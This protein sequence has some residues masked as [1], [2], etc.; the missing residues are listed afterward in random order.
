MSHNISERGELLLD[1]KF[2]VL[3]HG[4]VR[5]VDYMGTDE[6]IVQSA[7]VSYGE[8]TK[9]SREDKELI[10]YLLRNAHF[11]PFEQVVFT[12]HCKMPIFVA[13]QWIRHR[14]A[15]INEISGRYSEL[16]SEAYLPDLERIQPQSTTNKQ[17]SD[18]SG[19][20]LETQ[21]LIRSSMEEEQDYAFQYYRECLDNHNVS[22]EI[23][24]INLPLSTYTEWYWQIDLRNLFNFLK[25]R[26]DSHAQW[27]IQQ[28]GK[29]IRDIVKEIVPLAYESFERHI[30]CGCKIS[31]EEK[32]LLNNITDW[33]K[34]NSDD[35]THQ[36]LKNK[37]LTENNK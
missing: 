3:D 18:L 17:G 34:L 16:K 8:G 9:T 33:T 27:E 30:L 28:Y 2:N 5:L 15:R 12:F 14:S 21:D 4:F 26:L 19:F 22:R 31:K 35:K 1:Q 36:A 32:E 29:I 13:R 20:S 37:F 6:R 24:R 11:S 23:A 7:R 25:L 10:D